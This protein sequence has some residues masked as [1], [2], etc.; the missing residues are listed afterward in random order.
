MGRIYASLPLTG[1]TAGAGRDPDRLRF[2][3]RGA[4]RVRTGEGTDR[5]PLTGTY[6]EIRGDFD[7]LAERGVTEVFVDLNF[8]PR[9]SDPDADPAESM[10]HGE[11]A[12]EAFAP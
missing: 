1:P 4:V 7:A 12:L 3:C 8:D 2:V 6:E 5:R 9:V 10:R 11:A